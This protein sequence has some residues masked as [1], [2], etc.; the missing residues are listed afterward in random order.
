M[1]VC[2]ICKESK[3]E[4]EFY[5]RKGSP[6]GLRND[7]KVC[8]KLRSKIYS[9]KWYAQNK[10]YKTEQSK[11]YY[12]ENTELRNAQSKV[13]YQQNK[14]TI[15]KQHKIRYQ[16]T[17]EHRRLRHLRTQYNLSPER[18]DKI[19]QEQKNRCAI[20]N[21]LFSAENVFSVDH[22]HRCCDK[23]GSCG[24]CIRWLL[25]TFCNHLLG[26]AKDNPEILEAAKTKLLEWNNTFR[27][28]LCQK[29]WLK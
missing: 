23:Y 7:C 16:E 2:I 8:I 13:N 12:E 15:A 26:C 27:K 11:K 6:D 1:K 19:L 25:C 17:K 4:S 3:D 29:N 5:K 21:N 24:K 22:D 18:L 28:E 9:K 10:E 20:C 14:A